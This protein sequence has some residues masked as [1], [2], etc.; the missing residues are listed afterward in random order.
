MR[1][2]ARLTCRYP[3][4]G[5]NEF[6]DPPNLREQRFTGS[7]RHAQ[8]QA[9]DSAWGNSISIFYKSILQ[10]DPSIVSRKTL[11]KVSSF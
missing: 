6:E 4:Q 9:E 2:R 1:H 3:L 11:S 5:S 10:N 8:S 7:S